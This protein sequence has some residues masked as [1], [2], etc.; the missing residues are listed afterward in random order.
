M[1][2]SP[3]PKLWGE[4]KDGDGER[5]LAAKSGPMNP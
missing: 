3:S 5:R 2:Q 1:A 4:D